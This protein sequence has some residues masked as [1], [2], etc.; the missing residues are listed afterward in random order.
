MK[1]LVEASQEYNTLRQE[2]LESKRYVFERP[3]AIMAIAAIGLQS[4]EKPQ[5]IALPLA[6]SVLTLFNYWFTVNRLQS[7]ARIV[8][9]INL[10]LEPE[11]K[12]RWIG[13]EASLRCYRQWLRSRTE[14]EARD[15]VDANLELSAA[16]DA[17]MYY[18]PAYY[19]HEALMVFAVVLGT[20]QLLEGASV[21]TW[22][23]SV[24]T[25]ALGVWSVRYF[26]RWRPGRLRTAIERNRVIWQAA[27]AEPVVGNIEASAATSGP[28]Q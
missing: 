16:P 17:L 3:L 4:F 2:L 19:F 8:A 25:A 6:I 26:V 27:L 23:L 24:G 28:G 13:W 18:P 10:V 21:W 5:H 12:L 22:I 7:A 1:P 14:R 9:Y 11:A 20:V 15:F